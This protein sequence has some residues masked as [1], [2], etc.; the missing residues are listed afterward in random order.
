M[1]RDPDKELLGGCLLSGGI[2][3]VD[4]IVPIIVCTIRGTSNHD[5]NTSAGLMRMFLTAMAVTVVITFPV[6][7]RFGIAP[8]FG[9][10]GGFACGAAYWFLHLQQTIAKALAETGEP[11]EYLD[12]TMYLVPLAWFIIGAVAS[13]TPLLKNKRLDRE[14]S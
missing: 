11:T 9:A 4:L 10:L 6:V 1:S 13:L 2:A 12:S 14:E 8:G 5:I 7:R 3:L